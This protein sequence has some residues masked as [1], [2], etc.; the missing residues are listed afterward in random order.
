[1]FIFYSENW[2]LIFICEVILGT[3]FGIKPDFNLGPY[4]FIAIW[5]QGKLFLSEV[6]S[7]LVNFGDLG[8]EL[9]FPT[10]IYISIAQSFRKWLQETLL[11]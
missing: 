10:Y 6:V 4:L 3:G 2:I 1:M 9:L 5:V 8:F 7:S 11:H